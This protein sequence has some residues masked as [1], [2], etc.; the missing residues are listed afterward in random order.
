VSLA[1]AVPEPTTAAL[2]AATLGALAARRRP[3]PA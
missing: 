1:A 3:R 2:L